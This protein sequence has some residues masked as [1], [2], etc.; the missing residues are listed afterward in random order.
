[1]LAALPK[2]N[3]KLESVKLVLTLI[4]TGDNSIPESLQQHLIEVLNQA[5]SII[6]QPQNLSESIMPESIDLALEI[7]AMSELFTDL[8]SVSSIEGI[9][10]ELASKLLTSM[11]NHSVHQD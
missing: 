7:N 8:D 9:T 2:E 10:P 11:E 1:M 5:T 6:S 4:S 3:Q